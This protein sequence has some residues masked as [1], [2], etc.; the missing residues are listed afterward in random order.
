MEKEKEW[1][2]QGGGSSEGKDGRQTHFI[3]SH[4]TPFL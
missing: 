1:E 3:P 2:R 4:P